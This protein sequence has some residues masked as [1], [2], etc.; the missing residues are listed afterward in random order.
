MTFWPMEQADGRAS[1]FG[2]GTKP[3]DGCALSGERSKS[4]PVTADFETETI[5]K[6]ETKT[7]RRL[8]T[9]VVITCLLWCAHCCAPSAK[10]TEDGAAPPNAIGRGNKTQPCAG[11]FCTGSFFRTAT[12][13]R[14]AAAAASVVVRQNQS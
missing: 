14:E 13:R 7:E 5:L 1:V 11:D 2:L 9:M 3:P 6:P 10:C 8:T 12:R 4:W